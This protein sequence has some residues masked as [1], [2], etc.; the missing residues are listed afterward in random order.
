MQLSPIF[1]RQVVIIFINIPLLNMRTMVTDLFTCGI[2][3]A[4]KTYG[5]FGAS[6]HSCCKCWL[7]L[8]LY[9]QRQLHFPWNCWRQ[10]SNVSLACYDVTL[11]QEGMPHAYARPGYAT[12]R[13][14]SH[15]T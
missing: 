7:N 1:A 6:L 8:L 15:I 4:E 5:S 3:P 13:R 10:I 9:K 11:P 14:L 12:N 2:C